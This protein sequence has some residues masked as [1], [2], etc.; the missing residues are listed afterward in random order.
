MANEKL[1]NELIYSVDQ[2]MS[3]IPSRDVT[4]INFGNQVS[5][6]VTLP[7]RREEAETFVRKILHLGVKAENSGCP[8]MFDLDVGQNPISGNN[9]VIVR[10]Y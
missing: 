10:I 1:R 3:F 8:E 5:W 9:I 2:L 6:M 4:R 7:L